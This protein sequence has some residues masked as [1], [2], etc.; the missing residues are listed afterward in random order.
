MITGN[1]LVSDKYYILK[2]SD[3]I[4]VVV[5]SPKR[6]LAKCYLLVSMLLM[7]MPIILVILFAKEWLGEVS[8][9]VG[10]FFELIFLFLFALALNGFCFLQSGYEEWFSPLK[11]RTEITDKNCN[12]RHGKTHMDS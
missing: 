10:V 2:E 3:R 4:S 7:L 6:W 8:L 9:S 12:F 5:N 1:N 11:S